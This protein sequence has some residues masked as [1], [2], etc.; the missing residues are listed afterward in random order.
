MKGLTSDALPPGCGL[1]HKLLP[2]SAIWQIKSKPRRLPK[3]QSGICPC[4]LRAFLLSLLLVLHWR[5]RICSRHDGVIVLP[6]VQEVYPV[7][8]GRPSFPPSFGQPTNESPNKCTNARSNTPRAHPH[9]EERM[10]IDRSSHQTSLLAVVQQCSLWLAQYPDMM[11]HDHRVST[12]CNYAP[13]KAA[14]GNS[15]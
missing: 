1:P 9:T 8:A 2:T 5:F 6:S 12:L 3:I 7:Q 4:V 10:Q 11:G 15:T 13:G 14:G